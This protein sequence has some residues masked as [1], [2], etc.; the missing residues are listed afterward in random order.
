MLVG[1]TVVAGLILGGVYELT[2]GPIQKAEEEAASAAYVAVCPGAE[3]FQESEEL[4]A[5]ED[6]VSGECAGEHGNIAFESVYEGLDADGNLVG[7]VVNVTSKDGFGG[8]I[9]IS[10]GM[11]EDGTVTG[12]EFLT[13]NETAG[14]GMR[15]SEPEF[16]SQYIDV[17]VD[18]FELLK[19]DADEPGEIQA[20]SGATITSTAVTNAMNAALH[21]VA[22]LNE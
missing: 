8:E 20:L 7:Y 3:S 12:M 14:L 5:A 13:L 17:T 21:L 10:V 22:G 11:K 9:T 2:K 15:A 1:I 19:E 16:M 18:Q 6:T 4:L